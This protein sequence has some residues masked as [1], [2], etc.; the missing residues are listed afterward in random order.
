MA[1]LVALTETQVATPHMAAAVAA[2]AQ[3]AATLVVQVAQ[4]FLAQL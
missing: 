1:A 4:L 3:Q 2:G